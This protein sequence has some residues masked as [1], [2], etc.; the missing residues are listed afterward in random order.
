[1][2]KIFLKTILVLLVFGFALPAFAELS[3]PSAVEK[4]LGIL[5]SMFDPEMTIADIA[6]WLMGLA[7]TV[8]VLLII[9]SGIRY[10]ASSG[11][12]NEIDAAKTTLRYAIMGLIITILAIVIVNVIRSVI[13]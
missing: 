13:K 3:T 1:M 6:N 4:E 5:P 12:Q 11:E 8:A 9:I 2:K 10:I 7:A